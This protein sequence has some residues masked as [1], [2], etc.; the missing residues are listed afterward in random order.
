VNP[1]LQPAAADN[2]DATTGARAA[3]IIS[4]FRALSPMLAAPLLGAPAL[5]RG[6]RGDLAAMAISVRFSGHL[7]S[8]C[9]GRRQLEPI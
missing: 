9:P 3:A 4:A 8:G 2:R 5:Y 7:R 6:W 1:P